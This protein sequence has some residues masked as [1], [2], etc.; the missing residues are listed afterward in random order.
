M[1]SPHLI[2]LSIIPRAGYDFE[3]W[4]A[5]ERS[6]LVVG[7]DPRLNKYKTPV[8]H[9]GVPILRERR[10]KKGEQCGRDTYPSNRLILGQLFG[11]KPKSNLLGRRLESVRGVDQ[12]STD[13]DGVLT[14]D[15]A[16]IGFK[17]IGGAYDSALMTG[18]AAG[19]GLIIQLI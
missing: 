7:H 19:G 6:T 5:R 9:L 18:G 15:G 10:G 8:S 11:R 3:K 16:G 2:L 12:V 14:S 17:G 4:R 13:R 1:S